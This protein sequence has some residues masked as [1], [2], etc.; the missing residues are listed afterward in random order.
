MIGGRC[1]ACT[2]LPTTGAMHGSVAA[3]TCARAALHPLCKSAGQRP[4]T[5]RKGRQ[6]CLP[7]GSGPGQ[8]HGRRCCT[9]PPGRCLR[10]TPAL[11]ARRGAL[12]ALQRPATGTAQV[13]GRLPG[14]GGMA[15]L[16]RE[17]ARLPLGRPCRPMVWTPCAAA[18][19]RCPA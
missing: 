13:P 1:L 3:S 2:R 19:P 10:L 17:R 6:L 12:V 4:L 8:V 15:G 18:R 5:G 9:E 11:G 14:A 7:V 16:C